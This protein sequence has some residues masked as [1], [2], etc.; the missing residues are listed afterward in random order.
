MHGNRMR[1][2]IYTTEQVARLI[3]HAVLK[4]DATDDDIRRH[5]DMCRR[6]GVGCMCVRPTDIRL[7]VQAL[8]DAACKVGGVVGFP[9]GSSRS[10]A[11]ALEAR[12]AIEDGARELDMVMNIGRFLSGDDDHVRNDIAAVV[13]EAKP[14]G[15]LVKV[16]LESCYLDA[17]G[18]ARACRLAE[19][20]GAD[21]VKTSTGFA[22]GGA[23]PDAIRVMLDTVGGRLGV[24]ASGGIR[25]WEDAIGYLDQGC[26]RLGIGA[27]ETVLDGGRSSEAY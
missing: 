11:K 23:T 18:I 5:A 14:H 19:A 9:H 27:T 3:D 7:A 26:T 13:A 15:V 17:D 12:L 22:N 8:A 24:K 10:E 2:M 16:I 21:F 4:P 25:S 20:A 6:R 1:N